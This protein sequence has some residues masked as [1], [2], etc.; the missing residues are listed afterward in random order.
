MPPA[1]LVGGLRREA[2]R[3]LGRAHDVG[4]QD[5]HVLSGQEMPSRLKDTRVGEDPNGHRPDLGLRGVLD[6][7]RKCER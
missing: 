1:N 4:E 5:R 2:L 6:H 7:Q 3:Q